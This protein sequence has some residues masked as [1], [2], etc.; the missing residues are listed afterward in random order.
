MMRT[1]ALR[2]CPGQDLKLELE[3]FVQATHI[4]AGAVLACV[5]SLKSAHLRLADER[6]TKK[7]EQK[8]EIVSLSG[9][10][11]AEGL[12]LHI[13]MA[14]A[15]GKVLGGHLLEGCLVYTTAELVIGE[16]EGLRFAREYSEETGFKELK[17]LGAQE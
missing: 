16:L 17:I 6:A 9:T 4:Q 3:R 2:L 5:G 13:A 10:L 7:L 11:S 15:E 14:D 8:F 12:H 1:H